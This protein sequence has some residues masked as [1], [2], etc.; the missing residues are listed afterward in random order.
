MF[1]GR[2]VG[3]VSMAGSGNEGKTEGYH[4][5]KTV[6]IESLLA[7]VFMSL[8]VL[9]GISSCRT[10]PAGPLTS[11]ELRLLSI[12]VPEGQRLKAK[13]PYEVS[14]HFEA[15]GEPKIE[16]ACFYWSGDGPHCFKVKDVNYGSPGT[17]RVKVWTNSPG[18]YVLEIYVVYLRDGKP[19]KSN[20]IA[21]P[22][23]IGKQIKR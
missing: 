19:E 22:M 9:S 17:V 18:E 6:I 1:Q 21:S 13:K 10:V 7:V 5:E 4:R 8:F 3:T 20:V 14:I 12:D 23:A 16:T 11:G 15:E 2:N